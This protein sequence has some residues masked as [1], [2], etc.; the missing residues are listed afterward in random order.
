V[1]VDGQVHLKTSQMIK[2]EELRTLLRKR[3]YKILE[4]HYGNYSD[5][6]RDQLY[7]EILQALGGE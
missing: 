6:K 3:G 7:H 1:F 4:L 5:E 2:D